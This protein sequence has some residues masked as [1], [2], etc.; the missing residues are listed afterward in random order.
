MADYDDK[1][2]ENTMKYIF[3]V[4]VLSRY[5][6]SGWWVAGV[7]DPESVAEH[8]FRTAVVAYVL[9]KME[10]KENANEITVA[11]LFHDTEE[12]RLLD[13]H[14]LH[15]NYAKRDKAVQDK[16]ITDQM[17]LLPE[18]VSKDLGPL[19]IEKKDKV[20]LK[21]ADY[22]EMAVRAKEYMD[23]G[24]PEA[25]DWINNVGKVLQTKSARLLFEKLKTMKAHSWWHGLKQNVGELE[26][27]KDGQ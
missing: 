7:K 26:Y 19:L 11:A 16:V 15:S 24:Y 6:R 5:K 9:A 22:L 1:T 2:I 27:G 21:D 20:I 18:E 23:T 14:R 4:G 13:L 3:E 12:T 10:G 25:E 17:K 8:S